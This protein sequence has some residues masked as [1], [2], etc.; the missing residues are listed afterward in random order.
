MQSPEPDKP[1]TTDAEISGEEKDIGETEKNL[2][3]QPDKSLPVVVKP[4]WKR[5]FR[6]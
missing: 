2:V 3:D 6:M 5:L 1:N 4:W